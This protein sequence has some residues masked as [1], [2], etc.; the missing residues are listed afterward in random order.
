MVNMTVIIFF[1]IF[2]SVIKMNASFS[3]LF[4]PNRRSNPSQS[5]FRRTEFINVSMH[6][7]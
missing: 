3:S 7:A 5:G 1:H 2:P 6:G 4:V